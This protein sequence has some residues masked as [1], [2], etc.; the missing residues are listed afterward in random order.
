L[1]ANLQF[2]VQSDITAEYGIGF[3]FLNAFASPQTPGGSLLNIA[4]GLTLTDSWLGQ[5]AL[6]CMS[7]G[8]PYLQCDPYNTVAGNRNWRLVLTCVA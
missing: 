2:T 1:N 8:L 3:S 7:V 5:L 6:P 4:S